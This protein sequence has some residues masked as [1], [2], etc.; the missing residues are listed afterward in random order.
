MWLR[1]HHGRQSHTLTA[2]GRTAEQDRHACIEPSGDDVSVAESI[3]GLDDVIGADDSRGGEVQ[4]LEARLDELPCT[5]A[6]V[7]Q[8]DLEIEEAADGTSAREREPRVAGNKSEKLQSRTMCASCIAKVSRCARAIAPPAAH[9]SAWR[10]ACCMYLATCA[11]LIAG[12]G[13]ASAC[14]SS[15]ASAAASMAVVVAI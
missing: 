13:C 15:L 7:G 6:T 1:S 4:G 10:H 12:T 5:G 14:A 2:T 3:C 8:H 9:N 11:W